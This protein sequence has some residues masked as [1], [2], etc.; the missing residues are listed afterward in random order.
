MAR[1]VADAVALYDAIAGPDERDAATAASRPIGAIDT[2]RI[3]G[4]RLGVARNLAG[5]HDRVDLAFEEALAA[6]RELGAVLVDPA[7]VPHATELEE[8]EIE[9]LLFEFK[10]DLEA[11]L[12]GLGG[13]APRTLEGLIDFNRTHADAELV[14]FGQELFEK[15]VEKGPLTE[16]AYAQALATCGRLARTEG[17][18]AALATHR[19]DAIVA[20]TGGPAWLT[21]HVN[22]DHDS[23][24]NSSP[25]AVAGYPNVTVPMGL[26][27]G[28][29]VGLSFQG[30][31]R[32]EPVLAGLAAAFEQA[33]G[34]RAR[35]GFAPTLT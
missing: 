9:V 6:L 24:G 18:D 5:F 21:D 3:R 25:A 30:P 7:D 26:V 13:E 11:Y 32:S 15:A 20:P 29:P 1:T 23:G 34:H 22:G 14:H 2:D 33:T 8:P 4:A 19:L 31:A 12:A 17:L 16:P 35:P 10:A 27:S 28:L